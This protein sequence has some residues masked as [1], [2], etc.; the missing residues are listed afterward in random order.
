MELIK[1]KDWLFFFN[2]SGLKDVKKHQFYAKK[3]WKGTLVVEGTK[4]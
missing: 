2:N 1:I 3:R 4:I